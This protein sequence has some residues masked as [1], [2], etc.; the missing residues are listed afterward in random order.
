MLEILRGIVFIK[1]QSMFALH[2][3]NLE[4]LYKNLSFSIQLWK[5]ALKKLLN[6]IDGMYDFM[7]LSVLLSSTCVYKL[8]I[9]NKAFLEESDFQ[10]TL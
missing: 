7:F 10:V 4:P 6:H 1:V 3:W 9:G 5:F 8:G 2:S